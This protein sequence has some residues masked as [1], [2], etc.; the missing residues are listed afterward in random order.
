MIPLQVIVVREGRERATEMRLPQHHEAVQAF[1]FHGSDEPFGV[2]VAI[3][4]RAGRLD[5]PNSGGHE[6]L[7][8]R[9]APLRIAI[10]DQ[11]ASVP[12]TPVVCVGRRP[13]QLQHE[14]LIGM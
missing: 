8:N 11:E 2:S 7:P 9:K 6:C 4:R 10:A 12:Q 5:H 1:F 13:C 3:G 14:G